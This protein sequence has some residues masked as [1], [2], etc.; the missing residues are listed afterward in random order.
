[1]WNS[2]GGGFDSGFG[3]GN[4]G[5]FMNTQ[6]GAFASPAGQGE[7]KGRRTQNLVP[8]TLRSIHNSPDDTLKIHNTEV[9]MFKVVGLIQA[10]D[11]TSTKITYTI[12][13]TTSDIEVVHWLEEQDAVDTQPLREMTYCQVFGI[14]RTQGNKRYILSH[15]IRPVEDLNLITTHILEV[16][17]AVAKIQQIEK[18]QS[19]GVMETS[20]SAGG[21][22]ANSLVGASGFDGN[23]SM[24]SGGFS[25][26]Q[27]LNPTQ[28]MVFQVIRNCA[29]ETGVNKDV[30][31][32]QLEGKINKM[33]IGSV[34]DYLSSEGHIYSTIDEDHFK[35]T[36]G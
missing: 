23:T 11:I 7:K 36:D 18:M 5:G 15:R 34:L 10:V 1:M 17:Y 12:S 13:D 25:G 28:H 20:T 6:G 27:G 32:Q 33:Q 2:T 19:S 30:I 8:L 26:M 22:M 3:G 29:G 16:M 4:D 9:H 35:T 31:C 24:G 14:L 21:G